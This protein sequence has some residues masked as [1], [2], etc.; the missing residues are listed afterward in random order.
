[1]KKW[2]KI[3]MSQKNK[4]KARESVF[5]K[6]CYDKKLKTHKLTGKLHHLWAFS[7]DYKTRILFEFIGKKKE[8]IFHDFGGHE[9][10][11]EK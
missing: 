2:K 6:N 5:R 4:L 3:S 1:V 11:K 8:V 7:V 10:Y 9:I